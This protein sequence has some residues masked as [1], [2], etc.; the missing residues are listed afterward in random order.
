MKKLISGFVFVALTLTV[1][2]QSALQKRLDSLTAAYEQNG[3]H[4]VILVAKGNTVLYEKGYGLANFEKK[5]NHTPTTLFKTESVGKMFTAV[6]ILQLVENGQLRLDQTVKEL[7]PETQLKNADK[8]T[9]HHLLTHTSGL[10]SPWDSPKWKFK[11]NYSEQELEKLVEE[12]PL[13]FDQ[14]GKEMFYSNSGYI[15]LG[16]IIEKKAGVAFDQYLQK[17]LFSQLGM[18]HTR[19]LMDTIMPLKNGAQ[20]YRIISSKKYLTMDETVGPKA[21]A[22]GGWV[23]TAGDLH[24]FMAAL[25]GNKLIKPQTW[26]LMKAANNTN[27][28]DSSYRYYAY[29]LETYVNQLIPGTNL[30]G[31]N[32]GGAG[33]SIDAFV[34]PA[35]GYIVTS[36]TN[37]YQNSRPIMVNYMKAALDKPLTPVNRSASVRLYDLIEEKSIDSFV[38]NNDRYLKELNI[39]MH[40]GFIARMCDEFLAAQD[41]NTWK[42]WMQYGISLFPKEAMLLVFQGDGQL[43]MNDKTA[44]S[45]SYEA[46]KTLATT[47][48]D[49]NALRIIDNKLKSL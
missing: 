9:V 11:K 42:K 21:S 17:H 22:A 29:G 38:V 39:Q 3:Y 2:A 27:P 28:K 34:D 25:Y 14:P 47:N 10:Q 32:G 45:V 41:Y 36:C 13:A 12:V 30:Y 7:L 49:L 44:A 15:V 35:T 31:H 43:Q 40:P 46:A 48:N 5:I 19:H 8:I 23:S 37:L 18:R 4:G 26:E 16:W 6:S 20:P 33:F 24:K 1:Y